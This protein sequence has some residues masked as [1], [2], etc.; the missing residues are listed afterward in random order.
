MLSQLSWRGAALFL[1]PLPFPPQPSPP[2]APAQVP[3]TACLQEPWPHLS[4]SFIQLLSRAGWCDCFGRR[5]TPPSCQ[6]GTLTLRLASCASPANSCLAGPVCL[7]GVG[8]HLPATLTGGDGDPEK[9]ARGSRGCL[10]LVGPVRVARNSKMS[11]WPLCVFVAHIWR[12]LQMLSSGSSAK[13]SWSQWKSLGRGDC[14]REE[15]GEPG[16]PAAG[17]RFPHHEEIVWP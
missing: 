7:S 13:H 12:Q 1:A 14:Q 17:V 6:P 5:G 2:R 3:S 11:S 10:G 9:L 8:H 15:E 16:A 4:R